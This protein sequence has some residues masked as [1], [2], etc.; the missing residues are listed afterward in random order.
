MAGNDPTLPRPRKGP[1][2]PRGPHYRYQVPT[3]GRRTSD[4]EIIGEF[5]GISPTHL[6]VQVEPGTNEWF[7]LNQVLADTQWRKLAPGDPVQFFIPNAYNERR[8]TRG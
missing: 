1:K 8:R 4:V 2:E 6:L 5:V 7:P 3:R